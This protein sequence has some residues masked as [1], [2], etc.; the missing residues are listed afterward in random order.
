M[1]RWVRHP[2]SAGRVR[3]VLIVLALCLALYAVERWISW[4]EAL[5]P[6]RLR[7]PLRP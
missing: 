2:P 5:S 1:A 7:L 3:L 6:D 4:P